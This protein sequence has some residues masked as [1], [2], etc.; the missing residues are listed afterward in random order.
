[1]HSDPIAE[2]ARGR[3]RDILAAF[4]V[5]SKLTNR[6]N[7]PCPFCGG[8]DRFR[9]TDYEGKGGYICSQCESGSGFDFLMRLKGWDFRTAAQEVEKIVGDCRQVQDRSDADKR[10][11]MTKL[12]QSAN[13]ISPQDPV[14]LYLFRRCGVTQFPTSLRGVSSLRYFGSP[15]SYP[16]MLAKLTKPD[17]TPCNIHRTYLTAYGNKAP[18]DA[19]RRMMP[20]HVAKGSAVR[21]AP[22]ATHMGI[23]EGIETAISAQALF[24][25]PTWAALNAETLKAWDPPTGVENVT[26]F[27]DNDESFTG[28]AA[29]F[30]LARRLS[31]AGFTIETKIP[32]QIGQDWNDVLQAQMQE[33]GAQQCFTSAR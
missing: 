14:G 11:A 30:A 28:Q 9:F 5:P 12:W 19:P 25:V 13:A 4:G 2:R 33:A 10:A 1:M 32:E 7:Q 29:T 26:V 6:K 18:V 24:G 17:G 8:K 27:G 31:A 23:A 16:A 3:W 15:D 22:I 21:L 20:G